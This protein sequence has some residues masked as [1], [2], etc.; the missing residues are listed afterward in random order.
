MVQRYNFFWNLRNE[1]LEFC[2]ISGI[3]SLNLATFRELELL[4]QLEVFLNSKYVLFDKYFLEGGNAILLIED[5]HG[6]FVVD[7]VYGAE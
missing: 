6:F 4:R 1:F 3:D 5:K 2:Q 7:G